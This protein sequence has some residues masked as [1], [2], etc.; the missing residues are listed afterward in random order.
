MQRVVRGHKG[1]RRDELYAVL[2]G[3]TTGELSAEQA[4]KR[5]ER[6][7]HWVWTAI[8]PQSKLLV[9]M[10]VGARHLETA[11]RVVHQVVHVLAADCVPLFLTDEFK[12]YRTALLTHYCQWVQRPRR[13]APRPLPKPR[14]Q[15]LSQAPH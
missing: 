14:W 7:R 8:D 4:I 6:S 12:E 10:D 5:L 3:V 13:Q 2:R 1:L 9:A 15:A 11:Q